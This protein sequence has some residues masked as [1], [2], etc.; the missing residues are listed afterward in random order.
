MH[1][2]E[3]DLDAAVAGAVARG[4]LRAQLDMPEADV[5]L[6]AVPTPFKEGNHPDL[7]YVERATRSLAPGAEGRRGGDPRVDVAARD[8][9]AMSEWIAE[10]RPDLRL[11]ARAPRRPRRPRRPLPRAGAARARS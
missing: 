1:I 4:T 5:F 6:I 9:R 11:P 7:T 10:E 8:D 2:V 3:P